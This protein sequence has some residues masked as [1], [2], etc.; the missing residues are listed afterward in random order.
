MIRTPA[1]KKPKGRVRAEERRLRSL[2]FFQ[3]NKA[4]FD[5]E[6]QMRLL[7]DARSQ[8]EALENYLNDRAKIDEYLGTLNPA[9]RHAAD[10]AERHRKRGKL[11]KQMA[12]EAFRGRGAPEEMLQF[13]PTSYKNL[14]EAVQ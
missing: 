12:Q 6:K 11:V 4:M 13:Y 9:Y 7:R 2:E 10:A 1:P 14:R 8:A 5:K 3:K